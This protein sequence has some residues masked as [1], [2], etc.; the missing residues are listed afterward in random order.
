MSV[1]GESTHET[2]SQN[3]RI[4]IAR[5]AE[6][7]IR[8]S[9]TF[10][11]IPNDRPVPLSDGGSISLPSNQKHFEIPVFITDNSKRTF[12]GVLT[13]IADGKDICIRWKADRGSK[14]LGNIIATTND[15]V[16]LKSKKGTTA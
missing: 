10:L 16:S 13:G 1:S 11:L 12:E 9:I 3:Y 15:T 4:T 5:E 8:D 2:L 14:T 6:P 7:S